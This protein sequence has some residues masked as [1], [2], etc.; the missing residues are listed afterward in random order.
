MAKKGISVSCTHTGIQFTHGRGR[1]CQPENHSM[2]QTDEK[3]DFVPEIVLPST[4]G[5]SSK[6]MFYIAAFMV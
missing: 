5:L 1:F 2:C 3:V 4:G 6:C